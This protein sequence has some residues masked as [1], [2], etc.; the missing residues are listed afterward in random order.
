MMDQVK[1]WPVTSWKCGIKNYFDLMLGFTALNQMNKVSTKSIS[2]N[3]S[4][5]QKKNWGKR[6]ILKST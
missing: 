6:N 5:W 4:N 1:T 3:V 2:L